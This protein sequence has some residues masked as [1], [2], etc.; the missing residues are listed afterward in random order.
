L[1]AAAA[2]TA[3]NTFAA[4]GALR[5]TAV[6]ALQVGAAAAP[7]AGV[8]LYP[9]PSGKNRDADLE[10]VKRAIL[11]R[12]PEVLSQNVGYRVY[13]VVIALR[14]DGSIINSELRL[15][16]LSESAGDLEALR[17]LLPEGN[18]ASITALGE[19]ALLGDG[20]VLPARM[21]IMYEVLPAGYDESRSASIVERAVRAKFSNL[22]KPSDSEMLNRVTVIMS[23]DGRIQRDYLDTVDVKKPPSQLAD[24]F[25]PFR[26]MGFDP[27]QLSF[28]SATGIS[29]RPDGTPGT[30]GVREMPDGSLRRLP[31]ETLLISYAWMRRPG[32]ATGARQPSGD[33]PD[34]EAQEAVRRALMERYFPAA[35]APHDQAA[36]VSWCVFVLSAK[37]EVVR[38]G[39]VT[40][41]SGQGVGLR[42]LQGLIPD[43]KLIR[44]TM[45]GTVTNASGKHA[46]AVFAWL[47][48]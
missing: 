9:P 11:A 45:M 5:G 36:G 47:A 25:S 4:A 15:S 23:D 32:E 27:E 29:R 43:V 28:V 2:V 14:A 31:D 42:L 12:Y 7:V 37:G 38:T 18:R 26:A 44:L 24:R 16:T 33:S 3:R 39:Q 6:T 21:G 17:E 34:Y 35:F 8:P 1:P 46:N 48:P 19:G 13:S 40:T 30:A 41:E 20:Q 10:Q 22:M